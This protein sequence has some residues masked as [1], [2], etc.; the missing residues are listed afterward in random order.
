MLA[1]LAVSEHVDGN[2][3]AAYTHGCDLEGDTCDNEV[4]AGINERLVG[5]ATCSSHASTNGLEHNGAEIAADKDPWVEA[6]LD[7]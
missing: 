3:D 1:R 7:D 4:V 2:E 5:C 6:S